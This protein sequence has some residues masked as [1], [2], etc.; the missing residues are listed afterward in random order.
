MP[1]TVVVSWNTCKKGKSAASRVCKELRNFTGDYV[2][3]LQEVPAWGTLHGYTYSKHTILASTNSDCA[4]V[5]PRLW[6]P[7][8]REVSFGAYWC[9]LVVFNRIYIS[10]HVLDHLEEDGRASQLFH[11]TCSFVQRI[12]NAYSNYS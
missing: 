2:A 1:H 5:I 12:R 8:L 10:A 4:I 9:G 11:E 3:L 7:V 6:M